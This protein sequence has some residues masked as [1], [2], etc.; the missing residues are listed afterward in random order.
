MHVDY[1]HTWTKTSTVHSTNIIG[2]S[3]IYIESY[4]EK[5]QTD[6]FI[7]IKIFFQEV[8][9]KWHFVLQVF[10]NLKMICNLGPHHKSQIKFFFDLGT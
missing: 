6:I 3:Q 9:F 4:W 8:Y 10:Q 2:I 1:L 5:S 7:D